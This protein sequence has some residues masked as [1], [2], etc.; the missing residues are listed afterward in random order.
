MRAIEDLT[1]DECRKLIAEILSAVYG[2]HDFDARGEVQETLN[3]D[4]EWSPDTI[5]DV[6]DILIKYEL[7]PDEQI[8]LDARARIVDYVIREWDEEHMGALPT[9]DDEAVRIFEEYYAERNTPLPWRTGR[10]KAQS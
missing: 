5:Q 4:A 8:L 6:A 9:G 1:L 2:D 10:E 3:P 7:P